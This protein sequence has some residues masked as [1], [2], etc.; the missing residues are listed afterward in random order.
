MT[1]RSCLV[2][3]LTVPIIQRY[4]EVAAGSVA[5]NIVN[6][7][8]SDNVKQVKCDCA[9]FENPNM[10]C[11]ILTSCFGS[12]QILSKPTA[13]QIHE[14]CNEIQDLKVKARKGSTGARRRRAIYNFATFPEKKWTL[15]IPYLFDSSLTNEVYKTTIRNAISHIKDQTCITFNEIA[16]PPSDTGES[17]IQYAQSDGCAS[18]TG[19]STDFQYSPIYGT[20][21]CLDKFGEMVYYTVQ[22]LG[23][24]HE[25]QRPDS[26]RYVAVNLSNVNPENQADFTPV[27]GSLQ[28]S[29]G[30]PYGYASIMHFPGRIFSRNGEITLR[31]LDPLYQFAIGQRVQLAFLDSKILNQAYCSDVCSG[32]S[33]P[34]PCQN[35]G[36]QDPKD[37]T[38]CRCPDG[39]MGTACDIVESTVGEDVCGG[40]IPVT[41][42]DQIITS[43]GYGFPGYYDEDIGCTWQLLASSGSQIEL[44]FEDEFGLHCENFACYHWVEVRYQGLLNNT[45][46]RFCCSERPTAVLTSESSQVLVI[47][48]SNQTGLATTERRGFKI[49]FKLVQNGTE[50]SCLNGGTCVGSACICPP[51]FTG[52]NCETMTTTDCDGVTCLNGGSCQ[53][54]LCI[55]PPGFSGP[56]CQ[57]VTGGTG[58]VMV[59]RNGGSCINGTCACPVGYT[60]SACETGLPP[61]CQNVICLNGGT[62]NNGQCQCLA[63][64]TG[65]QCETVLTPTG[66]DPNPCRNNGTCSVSRFTNQVTCTCPSPFYGQRCENAWC[67]GCSAQP[68]YLQPKCQVLLTPLRTCNYTVTDYYQDCWCWIFFCEPKIKTRVVYYTCYEEKCCDNAAEYNN[69]SCGVAGWGEWSDCS[70]TCGGGQKIRY[71]YDFVNKANGSGRTINATRNETTDSC[72]TQDCE[73]DDM[74]IKRCAYSYRNGQCQ[75]PDPFENVDSYCYDQ[76]SCRKD[77]KDPWWCFWC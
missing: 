34:S 14:N 49:V 17:Y 42:V 52:A 12:N 40:S 57:T 75:V 55:C 27:P 8:G 15:P 25:S 60:G 6:I 26:D 38:R 71:Y 4:S 64:Y 74:D 59:C 36:Y 2:F 50:C 10:D 69:A 37:C 76:S 35:G 21:E 39:Y 73:C 28:E 65:S 67:G 68:G 29:Y 51:G 11:D 70:A 58:C 13:D 5:Q 7:C 72:N 45:G 19:R 61:A 77:D 31:T 30:Y 53:N 62:C 44:R 46:P 56:N 20:N 9:K 33:L 24:W 18:F 41:N 43:P 32:V 16:Q 47:F 63:G 23:L 48:R 54:G 22:T 1:F 3:L 66:C